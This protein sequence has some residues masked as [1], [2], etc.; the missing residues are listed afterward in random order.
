MSESAA[1]VVQ[2]KTDEETLHEEE[3]SPQ[4][5]HGGSG[6][7]KDG[8]GRAS[9]KVGSS[10]KASVDLMLDLEVRLEAGEDL[11]ENEDR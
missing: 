6:G 5:A 11:F 8:G 3:V 9:P 4:V 2:D 10:S 7:G 1:Q